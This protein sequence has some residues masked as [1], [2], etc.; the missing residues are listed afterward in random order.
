MEQQQHHH[1]SNTT[2]TPD[3]PRHWRLVVHGAAVDLTCAVPWL[4]QGVGCWVDHFDEDAWPDGFTPAIGNV[5]SYDPSMVA[6]HVSPDARRIHRPSETAEY[7]ELDERF[8]V[9][10]ERWGMTE[11]NVLKGHW[12]SWVLPQ[13]KLDPVRV[14]EA[15][16]VWPMAQALR[17]RA[18]HLVP[19]VSAVK[20]GWSVL[21]VCPYGLGSELSALIKDGYRIIG[22][23][24]TALREEDGRVA[25]LHVP[26]MIERP[27][28]G[29]SPRD[30]VGWVDLRREHRRSFQNH[31]FADAVLVV[32]AGR[33][34]RANLRRIE[35]PEAAT[36]LLR[37]TWPISEL[38][39]NRKPGNL[40]A[41]LAADCAVAEVQLS[42]NPKDLLALLRSLRDTDAAEQVAKLE[43]TL[44]PWATLP[45][46]RGSLAASRSVGVRA[47]M[48]S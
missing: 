48:A 32:E 12:R 19:A 24:W 6:R 45:A 15:S 21:L 16:V 25:M 23:R 30:S 44:T 3:A 18:V 41:K 38:H 4:Q 37:Q 28:G 43:L 40:P 17:A 35:D 46:R 39:P 13:P 8:W 26:G 9:V 34:P 27:T 5:E 33:R 7:Y 47:A 36:Q 22:Q 11:V 20:D 42:A 1:D 14:A 10:D 31:A 2:P 29:R